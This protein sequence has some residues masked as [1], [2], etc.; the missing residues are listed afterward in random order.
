MS[1]TSDEAAPRLHCLPDKTFHIRRNHVLI[2]RVQ[3][4]RFSQ[5]VNF[6]LVWQ[7]VELTVWQAPRLALTIN[8]IYRPRFYAS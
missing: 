4:R 6:R 1:G 7:D 3:G 8:K 5:P 2:G